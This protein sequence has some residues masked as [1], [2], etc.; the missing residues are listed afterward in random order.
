[1]RSE[2]FKKFP[3]FLRA[4]FFSIR[5]AYNTV[6]GVLLRQMELHTNHNFASRA[7]AALSCEDFNNFYGWL[8]VGISVIKVL[9]LL[10]CENAHG[11]PGG[12]EKRDWGPW[13]PTHTHGLFNRPQH[14]YFV[15][16]IKVPRATRSIEMK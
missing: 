11:I 7:A 9:L 12:S 16:I 1:M 3:L 6:H 13:A 14:F 4:V 5:Q 10:S 8:G 2:Q 15:S